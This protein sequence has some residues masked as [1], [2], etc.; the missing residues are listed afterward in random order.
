MDTVQIPR[1]DFSQSPPGTLWYS[2]ITVP[3]SSTSDAYLFPVANLS[4]IGV[5][6]N[7]GS[8]AI[9]F[10]F[11]SVEEI[12][13]DTAQWVAW[14]GTGLINP[15]VTGARIT[16]SGGGDIDIVMTARGEGY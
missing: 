2:K 3:G 16:N 7:T 11:D 5:S 4:G 12:E 1:K 15:A 6:W 10:T 9:E 14:G 8:P 13:N